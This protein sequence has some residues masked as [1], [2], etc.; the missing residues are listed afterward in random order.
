MRLNIDA[1]KAKRSR[2]A[3]GERSHREWEAGELLEVL[4]SESWKSH[5]GNKALSRHENACGLF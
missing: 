5:G 4:F 2:F 1:F 3:G